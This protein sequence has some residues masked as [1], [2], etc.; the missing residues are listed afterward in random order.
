MIDQPVI[1]KADRGRHRRTRTSDTTH[2]IALTPIPSNRSSDNDSPDP[3]KLQVDTPPR[4]QSSRFYLF[5]PSKPQ[6]KMLTTSSLFT[7]TR[8]ELVLLIT[9]TLVFTLIMQLEFSSNGPNGGRGL[10][11]NGRWPFQDSSGGEYDSHPGR[12]AHAFGQLSLEDADADWK[13]VLEEEGLL[14]RLY[15]TN[16]VGSIS[17]EGVG[18]WKEVTMNDSL[19]KWGNKGAPKTEIVAHSPGRSTN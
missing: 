5:S 16:D 11:F 10:R 7:P 15:G 6:S 2:H 9:L 3:G 8:R 14:Q 12:T 4:G 17:Y 1:Q 13:Q 19:S 18:R